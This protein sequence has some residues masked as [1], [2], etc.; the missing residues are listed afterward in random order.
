MVN[1]RWL[2]EWGRHLGRR[3][4]HVDPVGEHIQPPDLKGGRLLDP[5]TRPVE[6][7]HQHPVGV[8]D[9]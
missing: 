6:E 4:D 8:R 9:L 5:Q 3:L 2:G 7:A 1:T